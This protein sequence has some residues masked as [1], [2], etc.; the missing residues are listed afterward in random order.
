MKS[1]DRPSRGSGPRRDTRRAPAE[2]RPDPHASRAAE[3]ARTTGLPLASARLVAAGKAD[4][5]ELLKRM[6]FHD[7]VN[8]LIQ[9]HTLNRALATQVV[10]GHASLE[11][12]LLRRRVEAHLTANH[13]RS[14]LATA[15]ATGSDLTLGLHGHRVVR[16]KILVIDLYEITIRE[17]ESGAEERLHKL[18]IKYAYDPNDHKKVKKGLEYDKERR[19]RAVEPVKRPQDRYACSDKR[20]GVAMERK[21]AVTAV[22]LEG[23]CYTGEIVWISRYEFAIRTRHGG[24]VVLCRHALD[25]LREPKA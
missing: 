17:V 3:I 2:R 11:Q 23:E 13:D 19:D 16:A 7:E 24:E 22:T 15:L 10:L 21:L 9:R 14:I 4:V 5:N 8:S 18:Q 6:A 12:I 25:D 1:E 20:L